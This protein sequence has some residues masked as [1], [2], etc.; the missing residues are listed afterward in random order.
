MSFGTHGDGQNCF[1]CGVRFSLVKCD[2]DLGDGKL[3]DQDGIWYEF[4]EQGCHSVRHQ[5]TLCSGV[6]DSEYGHVGRSP[7]NIQGIESL[8]SGAVRTEDF[9]IEVKSGERKCRGVSGVI[10]PNLANV[11]IPFG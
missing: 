10:L 6:N 5:V 8:F 4:L 9:M 3:L 7:G 1:V 2:E 11:F